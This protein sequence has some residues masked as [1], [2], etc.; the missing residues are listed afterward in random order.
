[1]KH[2]K[3]TNMI[4]LDIGSTY[5][6]FVKLS[7]SG[8]GFHLE[9]F[10][11]LPLEDLNSLKE[12][13]TAKSVISAVIND[14]NAGLALM[15]APKMPPEELRDEVKA[16][17]AELFAFSLK[18]TV[19]DFE[20]LKE[21]KQGDKTTLRLL[22]ACSPAKA[23]ERYISLLEK[24]SIR[25]QSVMPVSAALRALVE[26]SNMVQKGKARAILEM[27][28]RYSELAIFSNGKI[29][30]SRKVPVAGDD[31]TKAMTG[32]LASEEG[33]TKLS[34]E[35]AEQIKRKI[36]IPPEGDSTVIDDKISAAQVLS[37]LRA[38]LNKLIDEINT[39]FNYYRQ[40]GAE[41]KIDS[42][43]LYG[44]GA[45]IKGLLEYLTKELGLKV[46]L[47]NPLE[48][49]GISVKGAQPQKR[50]AERLAPAIGAALSFG[51]GVNLIPHEAREKKREFIGYAA[52]AVALAI[53][54]F[55]G[56]L[57]YTN[58]KAKLT[59]LERQT[60][61]VQQQLDGIRPRLELAKVKNTLLAELAARPY[62]GDVF[63]EISN[64][65]PEDIYL[66]HISKRGELI[67][68]KGIS[69]SKSAE[70][71]ISDFLM[72]LEKGIFE[73]VKLI[74]IKK[75][76]ESARTFELTCRLE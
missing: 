18:D 48:D 28:A 35:E 30:F 39:C 25:P 19:L 29:D 73:D 49:A 26:K 13:N 72:D 14:A 63:K 1:M 33:E 52:G 27:G 69:A 76:H 8:G 54:I 31:F 61:L 20:V 53:L 24:H 51:E 4:G 7:R 70:K 10:Y 42:L 2:L 65:I 15:A 3:N 75:M 17:A 59:A 43:T 66:S 6:K 46:V 74:V 12:I 21:E 5:V 23:V 56:T 37:M 55:V 62:W 68:I 71:L 41:T 32:A 16:R 57:N 58:A 9:D 44:A 64:V 34:L 67:T 50:E 36:G 40:K 45:S 11:I 38:P 60:A 22:T 47:G